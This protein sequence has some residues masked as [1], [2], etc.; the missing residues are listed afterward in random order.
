ML[1]Q[2]RSLI[3]APERLHRWCLGDEVPSTVV[4][5]APFDAVIMMGNVWPSVLGEDAVTS[6]RIRNVVSGEESRLAADGMFVAI[7]HTPN[8][9]VFKDSLDLD[10][11]GYI[12]TEPGTTK[13]SIE[14]VFA[15]GDALPLRCK[16]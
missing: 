1:A 5:A 15:G 16:G 13:T 12:I 11:A 10:D 7:G 8:T 3:G 6:L 9:D 4:E 2:A 14:G